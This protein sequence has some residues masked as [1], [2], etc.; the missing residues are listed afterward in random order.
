MLFA[1]A[2]VAAQPGT[3]EIS[4]VQDGGDSPAARMTTMAERLA[5]V[6]AEQARASANATPAVA[7]API[8]STPLG[9]PAPSR[10]MANFGAGAA[11]DEAKADGNAWSGS[12]VLATLTALGVVVGLIFLFRWLV[13]KASGTPIATASSTVEVL[14]RSSVAPRS[15]VLL[16]RVGPRILVV[17]ESS[18]GL[19]TLSEVVD[20]QE[21]A[22][23]LQAVESARPQ[24]IAG[25]FSTL[26]SRFNRPYDEPDQGDPLDPRTEGRDVG[27]GQVDRA[28]DSLA[29]LSSR[30][31]L[32]SGKGD[33][34]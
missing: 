3:A 23:L 20:E 9:T 16:L 13:A 29:S 17:G 2:S 8:E 34:V 28:R 6:D 33:A 30:L 5:G 24:S 31:K 27:E 15:H 1:S 18:G 12:G 25:G 19:R 14:S 32:R 7:Q 22:S 4:T 21:V 11:G 26:L 10:R